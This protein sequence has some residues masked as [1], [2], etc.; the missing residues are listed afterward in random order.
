MGMM[1]CDIARKAQPISG[2]KN[3]L[4]GTLHSHLLKERDVFSLSF[5]R[6]KFWIELAGLRKKIAG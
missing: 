5:L 3:L 1:V 6:L 4:L 2:V